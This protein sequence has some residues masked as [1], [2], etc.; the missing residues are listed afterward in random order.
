MKKDI[1]LPL[2]VAVIFAAG[3]F[4]G[5]MKYQQTK[6][7]SGFTR[8]FGTRTGM[9]GRQGG[10]VMMRGQNASTGNMRMSFRPFFGEI[11]NS[12][13][14]SITV[15]LEDGSSKIIMLSDKTTIN[16]A[17]SATKAELVKGTKV[18]VFGQEDADGIV[19]AQSIQ[20][21]PTSPQK[22]KVTPTK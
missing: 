9:G 8:E 17:E 15:K 12:D 6:S 13:D 4:Y 5:G 14:K 7:G 16:K 1:V 21:N 3:G 10:N 20:L 2:V 19:S 18:S 22:I 11:I